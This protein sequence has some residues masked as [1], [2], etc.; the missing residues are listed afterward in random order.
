MLQL[1]IFDREF[2]H[3]SAQLLLMFIEMLAV[4]LL[5]TFIAHRLTLTS[6][7]LDAGLRCRRRRGHSVSQ[8]NLKLK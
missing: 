7:A 8:F 3:L 5:S 2:V 1:I 4:E 6:G